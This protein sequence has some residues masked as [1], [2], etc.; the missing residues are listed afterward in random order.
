VS[1]RTLP[2]LQRDAFFLILGGMWGSWTVYT[3]GP[4]PLMLISAA[5]MLGPGF[6]RLWLSGPGT[7]VSLPSPSQEPPEPSLS[8]LPGRPAP[9]PGE[10]DTG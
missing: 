6:L 9:D 8:S 10:G 1:K 5:V 3:A 7:R 2:A 4:W